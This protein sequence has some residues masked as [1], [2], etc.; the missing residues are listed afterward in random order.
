MSKKIRHTLFSGSGVFR[1]QPDVSV[2]FSGSAEKVR[3]SPFMPIFPLN[4]IPL[5][6]TRLK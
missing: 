5:I 1:D 2:P 3:I 4:I 6:F